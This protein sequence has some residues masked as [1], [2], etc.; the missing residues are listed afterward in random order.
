[1]RRTI[2]LFLALCLTFAG[3]GGMVFLLFFANGWKGWMIMS[4]GMLFTVGAVWLY[5]DFIDATPNEKS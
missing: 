4:A 1:M 3:A 2:S 5:S